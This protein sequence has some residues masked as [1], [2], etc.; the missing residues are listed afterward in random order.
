[1]L[2]YF[3]TKL[4][5]RLIHQIKIFLQRFLLVIL[6]LIKKKEIN[7]LRNVIR[8]LMMLSFDVIIFSNGTIH[9]FIMPT[10]ATAVALLLKTTFT[11]TTYNLTHHYCSLFY[12]L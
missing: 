8:Y 10:V 4:H 5:L 3:F 11:T 9:F 12:L 2:K 6:H 7:I 1:M